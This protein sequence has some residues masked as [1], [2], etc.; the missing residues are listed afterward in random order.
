MSEQIR[1]SERE[2][3]RSVEEEDSVRRSTKKKKDSHPLGENSEAKGPFR[4][5][6][7]PPPYG[8]SYKD[9]LLGEIPGAYE[10]AFFGEAV[11]SIP[12]EMK[13]RI[14]ASW[15]CSLDCKGLWEIS[16]LFIPDFE[17]ILKGGPWFIGDHFL[18]IRPWI[19][20]F[21]PSEASVTSVAVWIRL[22]E[23][24]VEYY[25]K[26]PLL[27]I[28]GSI[29]PVLRQTS[30]PTGD[31][32]GMEAADRDDELFGPWM[33]VTRCKR[34]G[35]QAGVGTSR[36]FVPGKEP[37]HTPSMISG[38][39][40]VPF[41]HMPHMDS[42]IV[43][44]DNVPRTNPHNIRHAGKNGYLLRKT[45]LKALTGPG[46]GQN[47]VGPEW[48]TSHDIGPNGT[49]IFSAG[50]SSSKAQPSYNTPC[51]NID[52]KSSNTVALLAPQSST[53]QLSLPALPNDQS[54]VSRDSPTPGPNEL[55]DP[56]WRSNRSNRR[57]HRQSHSPGP[58]TRVGMVQHRGDP[59]LGGDS[60]ETLLGGPTN[61]TTTHGPSLATGSQSLLELPLRPSKSSGSEQSVED[62]KS[63]IA[64]APISAIS[65]GGVSVNLSRVVRREEGIDDRPGISELER[66]RHLS[67][68]HPTGS[69]H[70]PVPAEDPNPRSPMPGNSRLQAQHEINNPDILILTETRLGGSRAAE[71][72]ATL[73]FAGFLCTKTIGFAGGIWCL[74]KSNALE[75]DHLCSTEQEIHVSVKK[76]VGNVPNHARISEY[77]DCMNRCNMIDLGFSGPKY[78]W[79]NLHDIS[80]LIMQRLDRAWANPSWNVLFPDALV[81]HLLRFHSDHC[82]ILL[83]LSRNSVCNLPRPFRFESMW[84]S[85]PDFM[86]VVIQAW[87]CSNLCDS[88]NSFTQ[89][90]TD[91]NRHTFGN[92]F[93][94]KRRVLNRLNGIQHALACS[95]SAALACLEKS[96]RLEFLSI[97]GQEEEFW[98][99]KSR[100]GW[101]LEGDRNTKF[102]HTTTIVRRKFNNIVRIRNSVGGWLETVEDVSNLFLNGYIDLFTSSHISSLTRFT[103]PSLAACVSDT[104]A[105]NIGLPVSPLEIKNSLWSFKPFKAP[106]PDGLHPGFFQRCWHHVGP[107]VIREVSSIFVTG[108]MPEYLNSTLISLVPKCLGP[109]L[110]GHFRPISLCNTVYKVVT[111]IIVNRIRP[112]LGELISPYQAAFVPG[113]RGVDNVIIAQELIHSMSKKKGASSQFAVKIDLEK[114]YDRLEWSFIREVLLFFR[115]PIHLVDLILDCVSSSSISILLNGGRLPSFKP[116]RGIRQGDPL[117]PYLFILCMEY[118]SLRIF[119][120][121]QD[122]S[123][124]PIKASRRG[125]AFSHLFF[126]DDLMLFS[127]ISEKSCLAMKMVLDNFCDISGQKISLPK[128]KIFFSPNTTPALRLKV[129]ST[130]GISETSDLG[131]YLGFPLK[132]SGRNS[133]DFNFIIEKVQAKLAS[134]KANLLS[135]A[136]RVVLIQSVTSAIPSYYMQNVA[137]PSR[138]CLDLDKLNRNFL[139]GSTEEKKKMHMVGWNKVCRAK[140]LGGLG[141]YATKPRN[142]VLLSKLNWRLLE[143]RDA[144]W[145]KTLSAKYLP[146]GPVINHLPS[147]RLGSSNWRALRAGHE[148]FRNGF[149]W[150]VNNGASVSFWFDKWVGKCPLR[151]LILGPL[152]QEEESFKVCDLVSDGGLWDLGKLSFSLPLELIQLIKGTH[153]S[154]FSP[155]HD[156]IVW[157]DPRGQFLLK[158]A[159]QL[160]LG[161]VNAN[162]SSNPTSWIWKVKTN[163]RIRFFLWQCFHNSVPVRSTL[164]RRGINI[165]ACCPICFFPE[166]SLVHLFRDCPCAAHF[167]KSVTAPDSTLNSFHLPFVDWIHI[168]CTSLVSHSSL[169]LPW[170]TL[171]AFSL[172]TLW[173]FRNQ[174]IFHPAH[175]PPDLLHKSI[176]LA[177]EFFYL[178]DVSTSPI[179]KKTI[180]F[181]WEC[182][183]SSWFKLNTD[184]SSLGNPGIAGGGGIQAELRALK[185]G[186]VMALEL[187]VLYLAVEM[188]SLVAVELVS[189]NRATNVVLSTVVDDCRYLL[190]RFEQT[191]V[192]HI[193]REANSCAD[194][195]AKA[196]AAQALDFISFNT[197]P[198]FVM[199]ALAFDCSNMFCTRLVAS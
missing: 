52:P 151:D 109:E 97:L 191:S 156:S 195:L 4:N 193:Y 94:R 71:L 70:N 190:S 199:E 147:H 120:S 7:N 108:K 38:Q 93:K 44:K 176:S 122:K 75:I 33:L 105:L 171:F 146:N 133:R 51:P 72:A 115:F 175:R 14:R 85:H 76:W 54:G 66:E 61:S 112:L 163:P 63:A 148:V 150:V 95:P 128:S 157:D 135:P 49:V 65:R 22:P 123:W 173:L 99:L 167:W 25:D 165:I 178:S 158:H 184:G 100:L 182:P 160:A 96:L 134:W 144:V 3:E 67:Q 37:V 152:T 91:W 139:W 45:G 55:G 2:V 69:V 80:S 34:Q 169:N 58:T 82:P 130:L 60:A 107:S 24:P 197:P 79:S 40:D 53:A 118:L 149:R 170:Q 83:S 46:F 13:A 92:I 129:V 21:K 187:D 36:K 28:G 19:P 179:P 124:H 113:R 35:T 41:M 6:S 116:S 62:S 42:L 131:K 185:D 159:Y 12:K 17:S 39:T 166:E 20:D 90:V 132:S 155:K 154:S 27:I 136:G 68:T 121:T 168:N 23:L 81:T 164:A 194:A 102:F 1:G 162:I 138:V 186:L 30:S 43:R 57:R 56:T 141:I 74:W 119:E 153:I 172:W 64:G 111:K 126:A 8:P 98:A 183:P 161:N 188:D 87:S 140:N 86:N 18:S 32:G 106:G 77:R 104:D 114:A 73:P 137:L 177:S 31:A 89:L 142:I 11:V 47:I 189:S 198:L 180:Q 5:P 143:E 84:L 174:V 127:G 26:G 110:F 181:K 16:W 50:A 103:A 125:P 101:V 88:I 15:N 196:G 9:K 10:Q 59:C 29:G 117:S 145:A 192:L 48:T 78:T